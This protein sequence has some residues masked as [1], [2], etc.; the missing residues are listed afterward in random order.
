MHTHVHNM[1][2]YTYPTSH[3]GMPYHSLF[4]VQKKKSCKNC[5]IADIQWFTTILSVTMHITFFAQLNLPTNLS[6]ETN[7]NVRAVNFSQTGVDDL[8]ILC[9][10]RCDSP[11]H[12]HSHKLHTLYTARM[13]NL[14][15]VFPRELLSLLLHSSK[16]W[17]EKNP[18]CLWFFKLSRISQLQCLH[19][20]CTCLVCGG[21]LHHLLL[22]KKHNYEFTK[23]NCSEANKYE[24]CI[25]P[26]TKQ[27]KGIHRVLHYLHGSCSHHD[28]IY[29]GYYIRII[30]FVLWV[31]VK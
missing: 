27:A 3:T 29:V 21:F 18:T 31:E 9:C 15:I 1:H 13:L 10:L 28:Y 11:T 26:T 2:A 17:G 4:S 7:K 12:V 20:D 24:I 23:Q 16:G 30:H 14:W 25:T 19:C 6:K 8:S 5:N 22:K